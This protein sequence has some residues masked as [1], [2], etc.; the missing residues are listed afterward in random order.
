MQY[1]TYITTMVF[2]PY[3]LKTVPIKTSEGIIV[4]NIFWKGCYDFFLS[5]RKLKVVLAEWH[6]YFSKKCWT[7]VQVATPVIPLFKH[8]I[9]PPFSD[10]DF[11]GL[12]TW[13]VVRGEA[14]VDKDTSDTRVLTKFSVKTL[15]FHFLS[16][17]FLLF[18]FFLWKYN[19]NA[20]RC[21]G[22]LYN[23]PTFY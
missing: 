12:V 21:D 20:M 3:R 15:A 23:A 19:C 10:G 11:P 16:L 8:V 4:L 9:L 6:K 1:G 18:N 7:L 13:F 17:A 22:I 5:F 2:V 14:W